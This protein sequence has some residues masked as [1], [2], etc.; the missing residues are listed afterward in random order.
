M[1]CLE[2][3][4]TN[5]TVLNPIGCNCLYK[6]HGT[7]LQAWFEQKQQY[8]CP[9]CHA[10]SLGPLHSRTN[11]V[12]GPLVRVVYVQREQEEDGIPERHQKCFGICCLGMIGWAIFINV[13]DYILYKR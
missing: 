8:E 10:V 9:I 6:S 13:L 7:C 1:F 2:Q 4:K 12:V 5:E 3:L 11:P